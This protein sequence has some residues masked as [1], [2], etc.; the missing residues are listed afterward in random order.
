MHDAFGAGERVYFTSASLTEQSRCC[1][2]EFRRFAPWGVLLTQICE[3]LKVMSEN[4]SGPESLSL[5]KETNRKLRLSHISNC[6]VTVPHTGNVAEMF[7]SMQPVRDSGEDLLNSSS[8][9]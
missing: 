5:Y 1:R 7:F 9:T 3:N 8:Q 2:V 4:K 6:R